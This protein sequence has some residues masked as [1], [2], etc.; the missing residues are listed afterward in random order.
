MTRS[1]QTLALGEGDQ[2][3]KKHRPLILIPSLLLLIIGV[4][5][6]YAQTGG[7]YDLNWWTVDGGG[8]TISGG[9]Y[10][11]IGTAGQPEPGSTLTG[12]GYALLSGFW[13]GGGDGP[14]C[15]VP[16]T[17]VSLS[18]PSS[19]STGHTL[20]FTASPQPGNATTPIDYT[21]STDGLLS[22]Q[23]APGV[24]YRWV[25]P[26][27]KTVQVTARNCGGQDFSDSQSVDISEEC[28][29]PIVGVSITGPSSGYTEAEYTFTASPDPSDATTPLTS[30]WS[31]DGLVS[32]QGTVSATYSWATTGDHT[33]SVDVDNCGG[34][35]R[36]DHTITLS[37][38]PSCP[39]PITGV[40]IGG[41]TS[42]DINADYTFTATVVPS[43]ATPPIA[44]VWSI[45]GLFSGQGTASATYRWSQA[46]H[47]QITLSASNC[48]G[49]KNDTHRIKVGVSSLYLPL[50]ARN[51]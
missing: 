2:T 27:N 19:G 48:G 30:S 31:T 17:G 45:D 7:G 37:E 1:Y 11:V 34:S 43:T 8:R 35:V 50:V 47:Y 20:T 23:G 16:L 29:R 49:S 13:P 10:T 15:P 40:N 26:G 9:A 12:G 6:V 22:G 42:G 21:W 5:I 24:E 44:Y 39:H 36:D 32:G 41:P 14:S 38:Q 25:S 4:A 51:H 46:G 3:M 18:G 33:I 28:P